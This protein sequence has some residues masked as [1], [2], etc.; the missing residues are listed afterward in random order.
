VRCSVYS[1]GDALVSQKMLL[2]LLLLEVVHLLE[3][4][5]MSLFVNVLDNDPNY[6]K[7]SKSFSLWGSI[8]TSNCATPCKKTSREVK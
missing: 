3:I 1:V 5:S 2:R 6:K 4:F 7:R 8:N